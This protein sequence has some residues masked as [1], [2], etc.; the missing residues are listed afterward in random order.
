MALIAIHSWRWA[1]AAA[2]F[3]KRLHISILIRPLVSVSGSSPQ[4]RSRQPVV[5]GTARIAQVRCLP[6]GRVGWRARGPVGKTLHSWPQARES[7]KIKLSRL[8]RS[9]SWWRKLGLVI[10]GSVEENLWRYS[11]WERDGG[12][13]QRA[14]GAL[15]T[16]VSLV[17]P[18]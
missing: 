8:T 2:A 6:Q 11:K 18:P 5:S 13:G 7:A 12:S 17:L 4:W 16:L 9:N 10:W 14:P 3:E 1:A 15:V